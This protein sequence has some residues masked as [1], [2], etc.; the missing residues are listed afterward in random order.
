MKKAYDSETLFGFGKKILKLKF[1][2][3]NS[4][5]S[6]T[7]AKKL[8]AQCNKLRGCVPTVVAIA[9]YKRMGPRI[10]IF[11]VKK[12]LKSIIKFTI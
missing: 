7:Q 9:L 3:R 5:R 11:R 12:Y 1:V 2:D 10:G 6:N 8:P 4:K